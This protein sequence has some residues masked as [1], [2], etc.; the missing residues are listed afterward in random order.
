[1][2]SNQGEIL[3]Y[4]QLV[5]SSKFLSLHVPAIPYRCLPN[6][7]L[8]LHFISV[9]L[10]SVIPFFL[11]C[12]HL[13]FML[14]IS[15]QFYI[16]LKCVVPGVWLSRTDN[17]LES[18]SFDL[19]SV[20]QFFPFEGLSSVLSQVR[21]TLMIHIIRFWVSEVFQS[22]FVL[23]IFWGTLLGLCHSASASL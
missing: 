21:I 2:K 15:G 8:S 5:F 9:S 3:C 22:L 1:M 23:D 7:F 19:Y 20:L 17:V 4:Y 6:F 13:N 14:W 16:C 12:V 18:E 10:S 11:L